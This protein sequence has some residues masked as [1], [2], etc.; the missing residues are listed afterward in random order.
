MRTL[1]IIATINQLEFGVLL[2]LIPILFLDHTSSF[3]FAGSISESIGLLLVSLIFLTFSF[4]QFI[5]APFL[6]Q[7]SD[8]FGRKNILFVSSIVIFLGHSLFLVGILQ[9]SLLILFAGRILT[10]L[11]DGVSGVFFASISDV[12]EGE[13]RIKKFGIIAGASGLGLVLGA[14][15]NFVFANGLLA[16]Q[17]TELI[18]F[19]I[20]LALAFLNIGIIGVSLPET[21]KY[22]QRLKIN[23]ISSLKSTYTSLISSNLRFVFQSIFL[24]VFSLTL[25]TTFTPAFLNNIVGLNQSQIGG[26]IFTFG[27]LIVLSQLLLIPHVIKRYSKINIIRSAFLAVGISVILL[28]QV[29]SMIQVYL[30]LVIAALAIGTLYTLLLSSVSLGSSYKEQGQ[31]MGAAMSI[32]TLAQMTPSIV[33]AFV[34]YNLGVQA[35]LYLSAALFLLSIFIVPKMFKIKPQIIQ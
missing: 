15:L 33:T 24:F 11:G 22:K 19:Y 26:V 9:S 21:I 3:S 14:L 18:P 30:L 25:F 31:N 23:F 32:Q 5:S 10:G 34:A 7:L 6:G 12:T 28:T 20:L 1:F 8:T 16:I 29:S 27:L 4:S 2:P 13:E 17:G 35:P